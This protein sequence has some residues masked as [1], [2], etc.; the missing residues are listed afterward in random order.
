M[1]LLK[2]S[3]RNLWRNPRRSFLILFTIALGICALMIYHGFNTGIMNQYREN[4]I[5][6]R[7]G[8]GQIT[9]KGYFAGVYE[10]PWDHWIEN[11]QEVKS[12]LEKIP[13]VKNIFPR[14]QFYALLSNGQITMAS[15]GQGILAEAERT[16]FNM[17]NVE[18]GEQL[19]T[20]E[21]GILLG[22]GL[23]RVLNVKVGDRVTVLANTIH[24]SMNAVDAYVVGI[25]HTG[26]K[27]FDDNVFRMPIAATK[28]LLDT[29]K[30][31]SISIGLDSVE[32]WSKVEKIIQQKFP[33]L[34]AI[35]FN[36]LD[37]VYYQNAVDFLQS[38]FKFIFTIIF[39]I[40][41]LGIF[42]N[43]SASVMERK[44]EIGNLRANGQTAKSILSL[45][46]AEG[47]W[48]ALSGA[49][50]G[51]L[52]AYGINL[53]VLS[54]GI[55]MP[56]GPGITRQFI[57]FVE[58]QPSFIPVVFFMAIF[59]TIVGTLLASWRILKTPIAELLRAHA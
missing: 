36:V 13:E 5:H 11:Y 56:P 45:L 19:G 29:L 42:N 35:S 24:G 41:S 49:A 39:I 47:I 22:N 40:V 50:V 57:T 53:T 34:E 55:A 51:I 4:T 6:S 32:S 43:I 31:E 37:K 20:Q 3:L 48:M 10:T 44:Y 26:S 59:S 12:E 23:A 16:F 52:L 30:V 8:H 1:M 2:L 46:L 54:G 7:Y 21:E 33:N 38:Q 18:E 9:L 27:E 28:Q 15:R 17:L 58:L 14:I 25:F